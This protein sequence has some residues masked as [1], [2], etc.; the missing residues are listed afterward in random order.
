L[1]AVSAP[2]ASA[3]SNSASALAQRS[4]S[5]ISVAV[6]VEVPDVFG[7]SAVH[8]AAM[9]GAQ[10][11]AKYLLQR[12]ASLHSTDENGNQP[13]QHALLGR[14]WGLAVD[15]VD[16]KIDLER[17]IVSYNEPKVTRSTFGYVVHNTCMGLA[18]L[19]IDAGIQITAAVRDALANSRFQLVLTLL[20]KTDSS[21][22][23]S[24]DEKGRNLLHVLGDFAPS[25]D[26]ARKAFNDQWALRISETLSKY[27]LPV[28]Q[29]RVRHS[30]SIRSRPL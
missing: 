15:L 25:E 9:L 29:V 1:C 24:T 3:S 5:G 7:R 22:I 20:A 21:K 14:H 27:A 26:G 13:F 16:K 10:I 12:G 23:K 11:C 17:P 8:Y 28:T 18:F 30:L 4:S 6:A 19:M 2:A